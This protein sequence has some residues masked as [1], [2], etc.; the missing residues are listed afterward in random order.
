M[1]TLLCC[2]YTKA[3][4][5]ANW[6]FFE[7]L[8]WMNEWWF[9]CFFLLLPF[10]VLML[11]RLVDCSIEMG[12]WTIHLVCAPSISI[13]TIFHFEWIKNVCQC[14][15]LARLFSLSRQFSLSTHIWFPIQF[16][17]QGKSKIKGFFSSDIP[18][19]YFKFINY[20]GYR[21]HVLFFFSAKCSRETNAMKM[22]WLFA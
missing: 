15:S 7:Q 14:F 1:I 4:L 13:N 16:L 19:R 20:C 22:C 21:I 8:E 2:R 3:L 6:W 17:C 12:K 11:F 5:H 10:H 9:V 18:V